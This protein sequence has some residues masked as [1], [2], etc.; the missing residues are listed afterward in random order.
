MIMAYEKEDETAVA[1]ELACAGG[2]CE[3]EEAPQTTTMVS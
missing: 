1:K 2:V 3:I